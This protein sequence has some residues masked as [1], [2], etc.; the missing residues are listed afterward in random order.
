[1]RYY[2][3]LWYWTWLWK[4]FLKITF[5]DDGSEDFDP[6]EILDLLS[7]DDATNSKDK[8]IK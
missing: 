5:S 3:H 7:E 8:G 6:N 1:M 2:C 4:Q